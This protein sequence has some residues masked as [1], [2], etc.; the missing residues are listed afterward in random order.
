[1]ANIELLDKII[2]QIEAHPELWDQKT[3]ARPADSG[4]GTAYCVAGWAAELTLPGPLKIHTGEFTGDFTDANGV[5]HDWRD[6]G[7]EALGLQ[8]F[9][10]DPLFSGANTL[11]RIKEL[12]DALAANP[13]VDLYQFDEDA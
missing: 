10:V 12:R 3:W 1:M 8:Y 2:A 11:D 7:R 6:Y 4:C 5:E 9:Q 13:N